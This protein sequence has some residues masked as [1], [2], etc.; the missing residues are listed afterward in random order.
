[1]MIIVFAFT[2][3]DNNERDI[4]DSEADLISS[5]QTL[6][7]SIARLLELCSMRSNVYLSSD[8]YVQE[9]VQVFFNLGR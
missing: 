8:S 3:S 5:L 9:D 4:N 2:V 1:M 6:Y 7:Q